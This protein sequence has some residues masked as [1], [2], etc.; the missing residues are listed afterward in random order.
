[1]E[2]IYLVGIDRVGMEYPDVW[3]RFLT[4]CLFLVVSFVLFL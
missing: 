3:T 1:M 4:R 2:P